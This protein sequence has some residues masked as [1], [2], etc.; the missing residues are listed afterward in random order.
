MGYFPEQNAANT[1]KIGQLLNEEIWGEM[2]RNTALWESILIA[3]NQFILMLW[4]TIEG[5]FTIKVK[6]IMYYHCCWQERL[7]HT[8]PPC[9]PDGKTSFSPAFGIS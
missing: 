2:L 4:K 6:V 8:S 3:I 9:S 1:Y 7:H 5:A